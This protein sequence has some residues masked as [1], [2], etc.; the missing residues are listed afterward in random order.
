MES[1]V[2][3]DGRPVR[4]SVIIPTKNGQQYLRTVLE[5][6]FA[7]QGIGQAEV[8]VIDSGS[9]D[10][11]LSIVAD[12]PAVRLATI[13]PEE[14]GHGKTRNL[15][16]RMAR[17]EF[18]VYIPQDATPI[19]CDWLDN[20]L[21]P[22]DDTLV[23]GVF[24]R[25]VPRPD[26]RSMERHFLLTT[27]HQRRETRRLGPHDRVSLARCLFSTVSGA[28]RAAT[29]MAHPFREDI[30]M[31]EDQA[32]AKE[33]MQAG[34]AIAYEPRAQ[35]L[36]SHRYGTAQ[37]FRRNFDSGY[38]IHQIYANRTGIPLTTGLMQLMSEIAFVLRTGPWTDRLAVLPYEVAR[39]LG[40]WLGMHAEWLPPGLRK[41][42]GNL[43]Y[44][45][46]QRAKD[47]GCRKP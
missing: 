36:H 17:G 47:M 32:W 13:P 22:F 23:A 28:V 12:F 4:A 5:M 25:Q 37:I 30:I 39:H 19:G 9:T 41:A 45:W 43:D 18:L 34:H 11:T 44:F 40:F 6:L 16:A 38:S 24:A 2:N 14:F 21:H 42:C 1:E 46:E 10:D 35:V 3:S 27:Y 15:G 31:S 8:I 29:W 7:Q 33:V 26:A 20:L